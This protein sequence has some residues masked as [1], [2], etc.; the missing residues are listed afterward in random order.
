[1]ARPAG[2]AEV[3]A[4][5]HGSFMVASNTRSGKQGPIRDLFLPLCCRT[6]ASKHMF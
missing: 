1:M 3:V 2:G 4:T 5:R 6:T